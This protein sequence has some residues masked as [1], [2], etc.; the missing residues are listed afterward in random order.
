MPGSAP[1]C[2][3]PFP[4][5]LELPLIHRSA[6]I[7]A[8]LSLFKVTLA[9]TLLSK[10]TALAIAQCKQDIAAPIEIASTPIDGR[11]WGPCPFWLIHLPVR[12]VVDV[13]SLSPV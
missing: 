11:L 13:I 5:V 4:V 12:P 9:S 8:G 10:I 3:Q 1:G 2:Y 7:R 6:E